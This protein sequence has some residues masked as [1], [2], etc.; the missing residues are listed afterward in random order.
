MVYA[1]LLGE[2]VSKYKVDCWLVNTGWSGGPFGV[3]KRMAI[4]YS[5]AIVRAVLEGALAE[6][7]TE[8]DPVFGLHVPTSCPG[9]PAEVLNPRNTWKDDNAYETKARELAAA[10]N[11]N[12]KQFAGDASPA[13]GDSAPSAGR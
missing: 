12:F 11:E 7:P 4:A 6:V 2:R 1:K 9:V 8:Q 10:F 5:R 13:V 3:G